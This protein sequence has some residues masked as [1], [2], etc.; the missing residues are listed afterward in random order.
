M[1]TA[2]L[3]AFSLANRWLQA[4]PRLPLRPSAVGLPV[5]SAFSALAIFVMPLQ[6]ATHTVSIVTDSVDVAPGDGACADAAGECSL[7]A[8]VMES[9]AAADADVIELG[10]S[11]YEITIP[12]C[13]EGTSIAFDD[14]C[15][16][17]DVTSEIR[18]RGVGA[19]R[20]MVTA[21]ALSGL[22]NGGHFDLSSLGSLTIEDLMLRDGGTLGSGGAIRNSGGQLRIFDSVLY[23]NS[24]SF[25]GGAIETRDGST[26]IERTL[27]S[28]NRSNTATIGGGGIYHSNAQPPTGTSLKIIDSTIAGNLANGGSASPPNSDG[29]GG[30]LSLGSDAAVELVQVTL[31]ENRANGKGGGIFISS[32]INSVVLKGCTVASNL[33]DADGDTGT[34]GTGNGGGLASLATAGVEV[35]NTIIADNLDPTPVSTAERPDCLGDLDLL[36]HS[37]IEV[38]GCTV[39]TSTNSLS[40]DPQLLSY[41]DRGGR[42]PT[43]G[44]DLSSPVRDAA[45]GNECPF[46]DARGRLRFQNGACDMGA[47]ES[48]YGPS[49]NVKVSMGT[50]DSSPGDEL[51]GADFLPSLP[52]CTL[53]AA[54]QEGSELAAASPLGTTIFLGPFTYTGNAGA[55][56]DI[57]GEDLGTEGDFDITGQ[58]SILIRGDDARTTVIEGNGSDRLFDVD[59]FS[60]GAAL[61][62]LDMSVRDGASDEMGGNILVRGQ[63]TFN[64]RRVTIADGVATQGG[65]LAIQASGQASLIETTVVGNG[66]FAAQNETGGEG[67]GVFA[68]GNDLEIVNS[69][70]VGNDAEGSGGGVAV[71]EGTYLFDA[72][73]IADNATDTDGD[74]V[75]DGGG[76]Y[77]AEEEQGTVANSVIAGNADVGGGE[78]PDC[79]G[80]VDSLGYN[81]IGITD[82]GCGF[83]A[84][85]DLAGSAASPLVAGLG[86]LANNGGS[87][88]TMAPLDGSPLIDAAHPT[89]CQ[90]R[91]QRGIVR[92]LDGDA[93]GI[94]RCDIGAVES[95]VS[96]VLFADG[97]ESGDL[98]RWNVP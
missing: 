51:C 89:T 10:E 69:T 67:G 84:T 16:D 74:D 47:W 34:A 1:P 42:I 96:S 55:G 38:P 77:F 4:R 60:E 70:I 6:A 95:A 85:G 76:V 83:L 90:A 45:D 18:I 29:N 37:L 94:V 78:A 43:L 68:G 80:L 93:D 61:T 82:G 35:R 2:V 5:W 56:V 81:L 7:R 36:S 50:P 49:F 32:T 17:L 44:F 48:G 19:Y 26:V 40:G 9:N 92:P 58:A 15:G 73:T 54:I 41:G 14:A 91:D 57:P 88:D 21:D 59:P 12:E 23:G 65:G 97:F 25:S 11:V 63:G 62:L 64:S 22:G 3:I 27:I 66:T 20:S 72:V 31:Y 46:V 75:G 53:R 30:G 98:S 33:A 13:G 24:A 52:V 39:N 28:G 8:A 79:A 86:S 87:T 71:L